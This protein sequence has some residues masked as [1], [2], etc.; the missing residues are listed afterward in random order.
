MG[1]KAAEK[2]DN[3]PKPMPLDKPEEFLYKLSCMKLLDERI[4]CFDFKD[5]FQEQHSDILK[6]L[7]Y[8]EKTIKFLSTDFKEEEKTSSEDDK[9]SEK[10]SKSPETSPR[11]STTSK[12]SKKIKRTNRPLQNF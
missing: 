12:T 2:D 10:S 11:S 8:L 3:I 9:K 7:E 5:K 4:E 1:M 6:N